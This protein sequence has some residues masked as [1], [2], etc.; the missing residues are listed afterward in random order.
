MITN[1][2]SL[3]LMVASAKISWVRGDPRNLSHCRGAPQHTVPHFVPTLDQKPSHMV[4]MRQGSESPV[5]VR[6]I[7]VIAIDLELLLLP[8]GELIIRWL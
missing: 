5:L 7:Y 1:L 8:D 2:F 6:E 3:E 4:A